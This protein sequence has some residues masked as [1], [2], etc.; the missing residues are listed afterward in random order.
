[1]SL[2]LAITRALHILI[3]CVLVHSCAL[4]TDVVPRRLYDLTTE[5]G[6]PH[7][8]ENLR[9]TTTR[10]QRCLT[11]NELWSA[12]PILRHAAL[13]GCKLAEESREEDV[14]SSALICEGGRGTTGTATWRLGGNE[15]TGMLEVKLG[16]K[17]MTFYQRVTARYLRECKSGESSALSLRTTL[18]RSLPE[19]LDPRGKCLQ[20]IRHELA[21]VGILQC[22]V[23]V[24]QRSDGWNVGLGVRHCGKIHRHRDLT[25]MMI[26]GHAA[27]RARCGADDCGGFAIPG[28][29]PPRA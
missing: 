8:D 19:P 2:E 25:Q 17:N 1:M 12:F 14:V 22:A 24:E 29:E 11:Q 6:M 9:Y 21:R 3:S 4:A 27:E 16:G 23:L 26:R 28:T 13:K 10:V 7:L 18:R 15:I 20:K 5:T